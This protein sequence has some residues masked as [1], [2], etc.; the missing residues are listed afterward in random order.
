MCDRLKADG[1]RG[2]W[3]ARKTGP[4]PRPL[5][6]GHQDPLAPRPRAGRARARAERGELA[7]GTVDS[8]LL[9]RLTGGARPRHRP[10][11]RLAH[12]LLRHP[13]G[14]PG[15]TS[16]PA[17]ST[18]RWRVLP[19]RAALGGRL[20]RDGGR[21]AVCPPAS[22]SPGIAG[23]QQA[24]LFGQA[25]FEPGTAKNTYGTGCFVLLNTGAR[26]GR[27]RAT[28]CSP[29]W[30][31]R[32]GGRVTYALEGSVFI[33]GAAVQWLRDGLGIIAQRRGD[34][35]RWPRRS[36][37]PAASTSCRPSSASARR[38]GTRTRA[39]P[40]SASR[41]APPALTSRGPR[42]RPSPIRAATC[43]DAMAADAGVA[44]S[45]PSAWTAAPPPT[46]SSAVPGRRARRRGPAAAR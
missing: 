7:F 24:A 27:L 5:L 18:C 35:R 12:A 33:A 11:Q 25:C 45:R 9:W 17:R 32:I 3:S 46:T 14:S 37:T 28:A 2:R 31:G 23:D 8:W 29:R 44:R 6:L 40:S 20:R 21:R 30:R 13:I 39:A 10:V 38:T 43:S 36:P 16:W 1:A 41:A 22:R 26:P 42:W 4:G 19:E 34:A 15:T